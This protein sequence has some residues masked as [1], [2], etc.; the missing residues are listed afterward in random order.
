[1]DAPVPLPPLREFARLT[2]EL[3]FANRFFLS[4]GPAALVEWVVSYALRHKRRVFAAGRRLYRARKHELHQ[5][6]PYSRREIGAPPPMLSG[7]GRINPV[8]VPYLYL[9]SD[10]QT[11][12]AEA[13]PW[14]GCKVTVG[15]FRMVHAVEVVNLSRR[16]FLR[17][18]RAGRDEEEAWKRLIS[19]LFSTPFDPRDDTAYVPT[20]YLAER[21]K[22]EGFGGI[23]YDSALRGEGYNVALFTPETARATRCSVVTVRAIGYRIHRT[24]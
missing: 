8:G 4:P 12:V 5:E 10:A 18:V 14:I 21:L 1:M 15:E 19:S 24:A 17:P 20:Q 16:R 3:R 6:R 22:R 7:Q 9:A 13:R 23:L 11:A 2:R